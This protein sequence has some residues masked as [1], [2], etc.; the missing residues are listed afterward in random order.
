MPLALEP[1]GAFRFVRA[2]YL[3]TIDEEDAGAAPA[4]PAPAS[5]AVE[6]LPS[7]SAPPEPPE[8]PFLRVFLK[9][10]DESGAVLRNA[11]GVPSSEAVV[12]Y[13][14]QM[15]APS[16]PDDI[17]RLALTVSKKIATLSTKSFEQLMCFSRF[18]KLLVLE[19][20]HYALELK[21][22]DHETLESLDS[23]ADAL[24]DKDR[25]KAG[26]K[27]DWDDLSDFD[28]TQLI[29][30]T[31]CKIL[32]HLDRNQYRIAQLRG[33]P[34]QAYDGFLRDARA[35]FFEAYVEAGDARAALFEAPSLEEEPSGN[36][37]GDDSSSDEEYEEELAHGDGTACLDEAAA[38]ET[39]AAIAEAEMEEEEDDQLDIDALLEV[40][41]PESA[42]AGGASG[43][44]YSETED[45]EE[46]DLEMAPPAARAAAAYGAA[47]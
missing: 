34:E 18:G 9:Y 22:M 12:P 39:A 36:D 21:A 2:P 13:D 46:E 10:R 31:R 16:V 29:D 32:R 15:A 8:L 41:D 20:D 42:P 5:T 38:R 11:V 37:A 3:S 23:Y 47:A 30:R 27:R 43:D 40:E 1:S 44:G 19:G 4:A 26:K 33:D 6:P 17:Y 25:R 7:V 28:R 14:S 35:A 24:R 45:D